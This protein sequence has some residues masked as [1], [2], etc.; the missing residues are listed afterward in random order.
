M[1]FAM[2]I[3]VLPRLPEIATD[4]SEHESSKR[5]A[6]G[7]VESQK[8]AGSTPPTLTVRTSTRPSC[9]V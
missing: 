4:D 5:S 6:Q 2:S 1:M 9:P 3:K 8:A 7:Y